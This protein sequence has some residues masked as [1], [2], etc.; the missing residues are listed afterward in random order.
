M[1][2]QREQ[3]LDYLYD[4][5]SPAS[6][7]DV[8]RHLEG[9]D[10]CRDEIRAFRNVREDLLAWGVPN[11][12]SVWTPFAPAPAVPWHK[13]V[14]A[15]AM[16]A[17]ASLML[18]V[19]SAGGFLAHGVA[20]ASGTGVSGLASAAVVP[21]VVA[22]APQV[23]AQAI[24]ALVRQELASAGRDGAARVP[25]NNDAAQS[26]RLDAA[27][28]QRLLARATQLVGVSEERQWSL[29]KAYVVEVA[30]EADRQRRVD[31]QELTA[32]RAKVDQLHAMVSQLAS[33]Q[34]KGQ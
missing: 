25:M 10:E 26:F 8:E 28:Q 33:L 30:R 6:R 29:L 18:V 31:G 16:A 32:L 11:P 2:E 23:D 9:C 1:C 14:P 7:R 15:W 20:G 3:V 34:T 22:P 4:E 27:T 19:G 21:A 12:P 13:Q 17:A 24:V 5:A